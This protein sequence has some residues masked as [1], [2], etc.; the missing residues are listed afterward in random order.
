MCNSTSF[1]TST[2][3]SVL[4]DLAIVLLSAAALFNTI[5]QNL[6]ARR[7]Q[8][9][10]NFQKEVANFIALGYDYSP[11]NFQ[12]IALSVKTIE[13]YLDKTNEQHLLFNQYI[14]QE[15]NS[16]P[17]FRQVIATERIQFIESADRIL[18]LANEIITEKQQ[19]FFD[20]I[21]ARMGY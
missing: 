6:R 10:L 8:W 20:K 13:L 21:I 7:E 11:E 14:Q 12:K 16:L 5:Y 17:V 2:V 19:T 15:L 9:V 4:K 3:F 1:D 18:E